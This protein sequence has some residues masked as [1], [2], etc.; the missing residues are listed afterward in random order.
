MK[1]MA[2]ERLSYISVSHI[3]NLRKSSGYKKYRCQ[4]EKTKSSKGIHI[5]EHRKP[6]ANGK[7]GYIRV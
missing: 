7:P 5:G 6:Q 2:Y 3:Y 4:Y 1:D